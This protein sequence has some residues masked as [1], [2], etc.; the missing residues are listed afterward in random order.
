[1]EG[2]LTGPQATWELQMRNKQLGPDDIQVSFLVFSAQKNGQF[3]AVLIA[4][5]FHLEYPA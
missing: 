5:N 4:P 3:L 1:M 2:T